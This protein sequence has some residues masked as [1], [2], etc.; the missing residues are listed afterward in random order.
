M[1]QF[2]QRSSR[3]CEECASISK[4]RGKQIHLQFVK[5][6]KNN[7][8]ILKFRFLAFCCFS[9]KA[10][11]VRELF[12]ARARFFARVTGLVKIAIFSG[13]LGDSNV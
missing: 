9:K 3:K 2:E 11:R 5:T 8:L 12:L 10:S 7:L 1:K 6:L 13:D 4:R